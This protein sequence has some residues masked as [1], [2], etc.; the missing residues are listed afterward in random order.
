[1]PNNKQKCDHCDN[2][3]V[4]LYMPKGDLSCEKCV[5]RGCSCQMELKPGVEET[6]EVIADDLD[7][8]S[9]PDEDY[10]QLTDKEGRLL[11]C[12]E[13]TYCEQGFDEGLTV[14]DI[15]EQEYQKAV[16]EGRAG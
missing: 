15:L 11:P 8:I 10:E 16:A 7:I 2:L 12:I 14:A 5:P 4:W 3:A 13:W 9:N 1:M 6:Y